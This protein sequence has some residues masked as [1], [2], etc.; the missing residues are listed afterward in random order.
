MGNTTN[1]E[2]YRSSTA[3]AHRMYG[4]GGVIIVI[5]IIIFKKQKQTE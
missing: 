3:H 2:P 5:I 4:G 1:K